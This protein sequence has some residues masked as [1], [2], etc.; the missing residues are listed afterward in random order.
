MAEP[1]TFNSL[2]EAIDTA[3][4]IQQLLVAEYQW[5]LWNKGLP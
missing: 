4:Y 2:A 5:K 3:N 1:I